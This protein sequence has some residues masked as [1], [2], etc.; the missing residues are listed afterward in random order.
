MEL[1]RTDFDNFEPIKS[2]YNLINRDNSILLMWYQIFA[3][4]MQCGYY[5]LIIYVYA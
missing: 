4:R 5:I 2:L 1:S 3:L